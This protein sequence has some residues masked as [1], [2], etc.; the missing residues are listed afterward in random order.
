MPER[1]ATVDEIPAEKPLKLRR[2]NG[3]FI[4]LFR[5]GEQVFALDDICP[6]EGGSLGEGEIEDGCVLC[7]L[8]AWSFDIETGECRN[9]PGV[10]VDTIPVYVRDGVVYYGE[11]S[12]G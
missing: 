12:H 9:M 4:A 11:A 5:K 1:L 8:H 10:D 6:H 2:E 7:P 3:E